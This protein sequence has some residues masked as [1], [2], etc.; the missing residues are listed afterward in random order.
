MSLKF[1]GNS[2][3]RKP[4]PDEASDLTLHPSGWE[5]FWNSR[6]L[7]VLFNEGGGV[8]HDAVHRS[9][10]STIVGAPVWNPAGPTLEHNG[11]NDETRFA[12][13]SYL[14]V[15]DNVTIIARILWPTA[16]NNE[17]V[18]GKRDSSVRTN[19]GSNL[20][21]STFNWYY[22]AGP[23]FR[24]LSFDWSTQFTTNRW[25]NI[26]YI[27][28]KAG[29]GTDA[30]VYNG[31]REI[32]RSLALANNVPDNANAGLNLGAS[33]DDTERGNVRFSCFH[34]LDRAI[35]PAQVEQISV[36][37]FAPFRSVRRSVGFVAAAAPG[38]LLLQSR[39]I[40][41]HIR[42]PN[43]ASYN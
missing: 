10:V 40:L 23:A 36:D 12:D 43:R 13:E 8:V 20:S 24:V 31:S 38:Q 17:G 26:I 39:R 32:A 33:F 37:V 3:T 1:Q 7:S 15:P 41:P 19:Y 2:L 30:F 9:R 35:T 21:G 14:D 5:W 28:R 29:S 16:P 11:V 6:R 42:I 22:D 27:F 4:S 18:F 25:Y 34:L